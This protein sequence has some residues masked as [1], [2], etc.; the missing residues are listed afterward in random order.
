MSIG[1]GRW[2]E[3][4]I[5][6]AVITSHIIHSLSYTGRASNLCCAIPSAYKRGSEL[7]HCTTDTFD[8]YYA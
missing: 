7:R 8:R 3:R 4:V 1:Q 6:A 5:A 2:K